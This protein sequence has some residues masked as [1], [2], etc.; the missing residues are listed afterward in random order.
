MV[1]TVWFQTSSSSSSITW[2]LI[3]NADSQRPSPPDLQSQQLRGRA[4]C[5]VASVVSMDHSQPGSTVH[6]IL[7]VRI[8]EGAVP[9]SRGSSRPRDQA[10]VSC[11]FSTAGRLLT[12]WATWEAHILTNPSG[13]WT[14]NLGIILIHPLTEITCIG[15]LNGC[16]WETEQQAWLWFKI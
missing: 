6:G 5:S 16:L 13:L 10:H 2:E 4:T 7:Q 11:V 12:Y 14:L 9:S 1:F 15:F 8:L 3:R